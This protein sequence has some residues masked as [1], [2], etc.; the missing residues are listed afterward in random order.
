MV[1]V[2][3][4]LQR[5]WPTT[6]LTWIINRTEATLVD[7]LPRVEFITFDKH[8]NLA[9]L[10]RLRRLLKDRRFDVLLL[11][12]VALRANLITPWIT[13]PLRIGF[14]RA[15]AKDLHGLFINRRIPAIPNQHVL[16]GFFSFIEVLGLTERNLRWDI[17]LSQADCTFAEQRLSG[18]APTLLISPCSSHSRRNWAADRYA[19][20]ANHAV[21]THGMRVVLCGGPT[22]LEQ[23]YGARI[24]ASLKV[25]PLNLIGQTSLK[26]LLA[27]MH[28]A[29]LVICPDSGPAHLATCVG[30]PVIGLYAATNPKRARPYLSGRWCV[31]KYPEA[32]WRFRR[33]PHEAL[34]WGTKL[35]YPGVMDMIEVSDVTE[36]LDHFMATRQANLLT[37]GDCGPGSLI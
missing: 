1:P 7:D 37:K 17:P 8:E 29:D 32:A 28:R 19:A 10:G 6:R 14:D 31:D 16:D 26:Q 12:Q 36:R 9:S 5:F 34:P 33:K 22:A 24:S 18:E 20:V 15:R 11:M 21:E 23:A 35:E 25:L 13:A 4:T 27:L 30:V 3:H 2:I